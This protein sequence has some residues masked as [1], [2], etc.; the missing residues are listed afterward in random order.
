MSQGSTEVL[1]SAINWTNGRR[2]KK[3]KKREREEQLRNN[4]R[5]SDWPQHIGNFLRIRRA[6]R[7]VD[8]IKV[9]AS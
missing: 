2:R 3:E 1:H 8:E 4:K 7:F 5:P 6:P 9:R